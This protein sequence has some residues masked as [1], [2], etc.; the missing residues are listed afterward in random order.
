MS[1]KKEGL[2]VAPTCCHKHVVQWLDEV[3]TKEQAGVLTYKEAPS[4]YLKLTSGDHKGRIVMKTHPVATFDNEEPQLY[5][6][7]FV[8]T[9]VWSRFSV[10]SWICVKD[11]EDCTCVRVGWGAT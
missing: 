4:G 6:T 3:E 1:L 7:W 9:P 8:H 2:L 10:F 11:I 5:V